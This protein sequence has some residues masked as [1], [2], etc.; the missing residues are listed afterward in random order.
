[1]RELNQQLRW[2]SY[3]SRHPGVAGGYQERCVEET[4]IP[5]RLHGK[6]PNLKSLIIR[7]FDFTHLHPNALLHY[8]L[9][10]PLVGLYLDNVVLRRPSEVWRFT[11]LVN[12]EYFE[13]SKSCRIL[14]YDVPHAIRSPIGTSLRDMWISATW[15]D[16]Q[17]I[18]KTCSFLRPLGSAVRLSVCPEN[19][20]A[21]DL[22]ALESV[23]IWEL[24]QQVFEQLCF[25]APPSSK[26]VKVELEWKTPRKV[27]VA[28]CRGC[29]SE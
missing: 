6:L 19:T 8:T 29:T 15:P 23:P 2:D 28:L 14:Q 26:L 3:G 13:L 4:G 16:L 11:Q 22:P 27:S 9:F 5:H 17:R 12:A 18:S 1:M 25:S 7:N 24:L 20:E 10:R 21:N